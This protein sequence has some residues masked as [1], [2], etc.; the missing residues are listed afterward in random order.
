MKLLQ[1]TLFIDMLG[2]RDI[3]GNINTEDAASEFIRFME[4]NKFILDFQNNQLIEECYRSSDQFNLYEY[5]DIKYAFVSDSLILT[6]YPLD[7]ETLTNI[8]K[9]YMHSANAL[10]IITMRLLNF[11]FNCFHEKNVFLRGGIS[12]KYCYIKDSFVVGEGLIE[13]YKAESKIAVYPRIAFAADVTNNKNL[14]A[15]IEYISNIMYGGNQLIS[16]DSNDNVAFLD[17]LGFQ[18][19]TVDISD[20]KI[21]QQVLNHREWFDKHLNIVET[22]IKEH[23]SKI[24]DKLQELH[25]KR[26]SLSKIKKAEIDKVIEKFEWLKSYHNTSVTK[27][28]ILSH[29]VVK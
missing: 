12:N 3:N 21:Q 5:Y 2:Y 17:Y 28:D 16:I 22:Y 25:N 15:K 10:F 29:L 24:E 13:A 6:Y 4:S 27:N 20:S 19:A 9:M 8:D 26:S 23:A 11:F 18:L 1:W 7:V 14:M